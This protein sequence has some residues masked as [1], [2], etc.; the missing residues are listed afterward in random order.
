[1]DAKYSM[2]DIRIFLDEYKSTQEPKPADWMLSVPLVGRRM[3]EK[4]V[5]QEHRINYFEKNI[6]KL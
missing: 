2:E 4:A 6:M 1:M 3:Y 5:L